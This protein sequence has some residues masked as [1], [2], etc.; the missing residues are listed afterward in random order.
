MQP[1][2]ITGSTIAHMELDEGMDHDF[3]FQ[4]LND[5]TLL[6]ID[7]TGWEADLQVKMT[8]GSMQVLNQLSSKEASTK[9]S[10]SLSNKG[11]IQV[12]FTGEFTLGAQWA[13][14]FYD[15]VL[16]NTAS[17]KTKL[18]RGKIHIY[19]TVT[20]P[21]IEVSSESMSMRIA[22]HTLP[23]GI[24]AWGFMDAIRLGVGGGVQSYGL[25]TP[26]IQDRFEVIELSW[27]SYEV[28]LRLKGEI[29]SSDFSAVIAGYAKYNTS[30]AVRVFDNQAIGGLGMTSFV[31][32]FQNNPFIGLE[33]STL[34]VSLVT[35]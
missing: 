3:K 30:E 21:A 6:P 28:S 17:R 29:S 12:S 1:L 24:V 19:N 10:I 15:L 27:A 22:S 35:T 31:W 11:L 5:S 33:G 8:M 16:T 20:L 34:P 13:D 9:G 32:T 25:L 14:A 2:K 23:N 26:F 7:L 18:L 4:Y